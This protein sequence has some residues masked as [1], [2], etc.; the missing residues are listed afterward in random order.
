MKTVYRKSLILRCLFFLT[1]IF[2]LYA[3]IITI[4]TQEDISISIWIVMM[5]IISINA[6]ALIDYVFSK[7]E[8]QED[9]FTY[10]KV[11]IRVVIRKDEV[12]FARSLCDADIIKNK[13]IIYK[14]NGDKI[15]LKG[16]LD[17]FS[18]K[19]KMDLLADLLVFFRKKI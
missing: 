11:F 4:L 2:F 5:T 18:M 14:K 8:F 7:I 17:G 1:L 19:T 6:W 16:G 15:K 10:K 13:Y 12:D 3:A 9:V